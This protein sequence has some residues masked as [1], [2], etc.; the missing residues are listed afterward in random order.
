[1]MDMTLLWMFRWRERKCEAVC[2][3]QGR[4]QERVA[5]EAT[6]NGVLMVAAAAKIVAKGGHVRRGVAEE[7]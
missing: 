2:P 6:V 4:K 1:M 3:A 7:Q 5:R